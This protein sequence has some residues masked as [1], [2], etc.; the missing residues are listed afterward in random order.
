MSFHRQRKAFRLSHLVELVQAASR[1]IASG[2][3]PP[4]GPW[5]YLLLALLVA[6]EGPIAV[7]LGAAAASAGLLQPEK[8]FLAAAIGN[9]AADVLWYTL[10]YMGRIETLLRFAERHGLR[11][12]LLE[13]LRQSMQDNALK[14][15]FFAKLTLSFVIPAL[16]TAGLLRLPLRRWLPAL[17]A[18]ETI[19]TG[20]L[21][22]V[23]FYATEAIRR[24]ERG[25]E[26]AILVASLS[27]LVLLIRSG[28]RIQARWRLDAVAPDSRERP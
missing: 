28:R 13:H 25:L 26:Y 12:E 20:S 23:G 19:W 16:L 6:I 2:Q 17:V 15:L 5:T 10:G 7:L 3:L 22:L 9:L 8:V 4:L 1:S 11:R 18:A 21:V 24:V 14:V 27:F